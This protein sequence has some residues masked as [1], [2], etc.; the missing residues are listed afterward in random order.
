MSER[1]KRLGGGPKNIVLANL[2][3]GV[4]KADVYEPS[5]NPLYRDVLKHYGVVA[6]PCRVRH[7]NRK[8]KVESAVGNA[9]RTPLAGMRFESLNRGSRLSTP[10]KTL[11]S[12]GR[13]S[14]RWR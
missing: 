8:G 10:G 7:P 3:E 9:Q 1:F 4:L 11:V 13:R 6:F 2:K 5:L 12:T 14:G